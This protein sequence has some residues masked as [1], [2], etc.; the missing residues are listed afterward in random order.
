MQNEIRDEDL[1]AQLKA[2]EGTVAYKA[3]CGVL[4]ATQARRDKAAAELAHKTAEVVSLPREARRRRVAREVIET[5]APTISDIRHIHSVLAICGLPYERLPLEERDYGVVQGNMAVDVQAGFL[6]DG[7]GQKIYQPVPFGPKARLILMHLC[8]EAVRQKSPT[9]EIADTLTGFVRDMGFSDSGGKRGPLTAFREQINA[10]AAC[11]MR[12]TARDPRQPKLRSKSFTPFE[13]FDV[14]LGSGNPDQRNLWPSTISFS[15]TMYDSL[16]K[17]A[18]PV[19]THAVRAFA[20]SARKLDLYF[21]LGW[22]MYNISAPLQIGWGSLRDQFGKNIAR[23]RK[24]KEM[25]AG[26]LRDVLEVFPRAPAS[27][28]DE[29]LRLEPASAEVL[30]LPR[31]KARKT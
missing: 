25:F 23:E 31:L 15:P 4:A 6:R 21:W 8:S 29:G 17:H 12:I 18:L 5:T 2:A 24:F 11:T 10:L 16:V 14:W 19:N 26:E 9:I 13:E 20:G 28:S 22:R 27:L 1:L 30:S 7:K 3:V